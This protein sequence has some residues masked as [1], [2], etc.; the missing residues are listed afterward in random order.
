MKW[1][2]GVAGAAEGWAHATG[3]KIEHRW[4][5]A[6]RNGAGAGMACAA[7]LGVENAGATPD[8]AARGRAATALSRLPGGASRRQGGP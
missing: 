4:P 2:I 1:R 3:T 7:A 8:G 6:R 5:W